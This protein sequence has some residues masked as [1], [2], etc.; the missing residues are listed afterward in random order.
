MITVTG[1]LTFDDY[2]VAM[3]YHLLKRNLF[4]IF[5]FIGAAFVT[6]VNRE[7][8]VS[9]VFFVYLAIRPFYFRS[10]YKRIWEQTPS[11][12]KLSET[13]GFDEDGFHTKDDNENLSIL[14]WDNFIKWKEAK[15]TILIYLAPH[16]FIFLPK[17]FVRADEQNRIKELLKQKIEQTPG[18]V[19]PSILLI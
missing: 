2:I 7:Y 4:F 11:F 19:R 18:K 8:F 6:T 5:L 12:D 16:Q 1:Q 10:H 9:G 15:N 3:K 14:H 17:R 13:Y